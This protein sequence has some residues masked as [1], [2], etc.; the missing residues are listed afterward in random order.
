MMAAREGQ[1]GMVRLLLA[2]GADP[3]LTNTEGLTAAQIA[4]RAGQT[5]IAASISGFKR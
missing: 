1:P 4:Q 5:N 2:A 3:A